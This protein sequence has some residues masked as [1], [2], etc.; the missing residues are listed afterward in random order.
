MENHIRQRLD[1]LPRLDERIGSVHVTLE[2]DAHGQHVEIVAK[3]HK[4]VLVANAR[5]HDIYVSIEES[6]DKMERQIARRHDKLV[7]N[8]ARKAQQTAEGDKHPQ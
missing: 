7:H 5:S 6:F 4:S 8:R 1:K 3:Y 2:G